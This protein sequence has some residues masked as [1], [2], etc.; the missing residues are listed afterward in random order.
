MGEGSEKCSRVLSHS[1]TPSIVSTGRSVRPL[2]G[3]RTFNEKSGFKRKQHVVIPRKTINMCI[4]FFL[5][6]AKLVGSIVE[7]EF[8]RS[9]NSTIH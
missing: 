4:G 9:E 1:D 3:N 8:T 2:T 6:M 7:H 5:Q